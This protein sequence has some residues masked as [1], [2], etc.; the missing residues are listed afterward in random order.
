MGPQV[1]L[2]YILCCTTLKLILEEIYCFEFLKMIN[3][4]AYVLYN[5]KYYDSHNHK[6]NIGYNNI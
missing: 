3:F 1:T 2:K 6:H 4:K 5:Y